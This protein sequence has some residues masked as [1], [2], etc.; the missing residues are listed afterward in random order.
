MAKKTFA[1]KSF[2]AKSFACGTWRGV[3]VVAPTGGS[4]GGRGATGP[5]MLT[6]KGAI[7]H[8]P[9]LR[10]T[11]QLGRPAPDPAWLDWLHRRKRRRRDE[12]VLLS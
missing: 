7:R 10:P 3:P 5:I 2:A 9:E 12:E 1:A 8:G 4:G 6:K 11:R